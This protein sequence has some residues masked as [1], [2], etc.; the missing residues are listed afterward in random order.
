MSKRMKLRI[1]SRLVK[2]KSRKQS[3]GGTKH[4]RFTDRPEQ[5]TLI[6]YKN[7]AFLRSFMT[8]RNKILPAR[9]SGTSLFYQ[10]EIA[11]Q[12]KLARSM[13]LLPFCPIHI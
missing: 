4:C 3:F 8:E 7:V 9:V 11:R 5:Q 2:K 6:D 1:S 12:I 13:A 10:R